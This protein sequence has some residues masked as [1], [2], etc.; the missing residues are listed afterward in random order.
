MKNANIILMY[1]QSCESQNKSSVVSLAMLNILLDFSQIFDPIKVENAFHA[2]LI[3]LFPLFSQIYLQ[4]AK[5]LLFACTRSC[6][7]WWSKSHRFN[8]A[9]TI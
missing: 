9:H 7:I 5:I 4:H 6:L 1:S 2:S 3:P 8:H